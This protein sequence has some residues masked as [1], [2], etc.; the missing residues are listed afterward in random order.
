MAG[1]QPWLA[2]W[3]KLKESRYSTLDW[4]PKPFEHVERGPYN[5]PNIGSSEFS[6]DARA[7]YNHALCWA[8]SGEEAHAKKAAQITNA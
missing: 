4:K 3:E 7:A 6:N 8:L 5:D 1:E 2:A